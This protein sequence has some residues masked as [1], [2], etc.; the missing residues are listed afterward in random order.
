MAPP[1]VVLMTS[2]KIAFEY[3]LTGVGPG[4]GGG[5]GGGFPEP[6]RAPAG[7]D[8]RAF[9]RHRH[10]PEARTGGASRAEPCHMKM[11]SRRATCGGRC[12]SVLSC[13]RSAYRHGLRVG[14][15]R[16][17]LQAVDVNVRARASSGALGSG[18]G[19]CSGA[20]TRATYALISN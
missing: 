4:G 2:S 12:L 17:V 1:Q 18:S 7:V 13:D 15:R 14:V 9:S 8:A 6:V 19:C 3:V 11:R 16:H 20:S 5:G 10:W